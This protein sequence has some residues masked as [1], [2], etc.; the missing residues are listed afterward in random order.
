MRVLAVI[1]FNSV[2][3]LTSAF[4]SWTVQAYFPNWNKKKWQKSYRYPELRERCHNSLP[5]WT[6]EDNIDL[7]ARWL[8]YVKRC[9]HLQEGNSVVVN[10]S[11]LTVP[12]ELSQWS[13]SCKGFR[14]NHPVVRKQT[15]SKAA[16]V[17]VESVG[18]TGDLLSSSIHFSTVW[19]TGTLPKQSTDSNG[20]SF[21][22]L[23][24]LPPVDTNRWGYFPGNV[25]STQF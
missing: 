8:F 9:I 11:K 14:I 17:C 25:K 13:W 23:T 15:T 19:L 4:R 12:C 2:L 18:L 24:G 5:V 21:P 3:V 7:T 1:P 6:L 10:G 22:G 16:W 20:P